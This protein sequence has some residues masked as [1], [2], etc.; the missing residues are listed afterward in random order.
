MFVALWRSKFT[1]HT[2]LGQRI[3]TRRSARC[4]AGER[5]PFRIFT[6]HTGTTRS[7]RVANQALNSQRAVHHISR[8]CVATEDARQVKGTNFASPLRRGIFVCSPML[9]Q[10]SVS[11]L[12]AKRSRVRACYIVLLWRFTGL[13]SSSQE[14]WCVRVVV[15]QNGARRF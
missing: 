14:T 5:L 13:G 4:A 8:T 2:S 12:P 7:G 11:Q 3:I 10:P 15:M 1:G 6:L 9:A